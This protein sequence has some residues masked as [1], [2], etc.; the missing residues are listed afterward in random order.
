MI[1]LG[2]FSRTKSRTIGCMVEGLE[3]LPWVQ[4]APRAG[5]GTGDRQLALGQGDRLKASPSSLA[6]RCTA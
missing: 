1:P 6:Y 2:R 3:S 5:A 4:G